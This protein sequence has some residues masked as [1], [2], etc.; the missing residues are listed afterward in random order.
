LGLILKP[1]GGFSGQKPIAKG[2]KKG[3]IMNK[4]LRKK[5]IVNPPLQFKLMFL[6]LL[7]II[8]PALLTF[9]TLFFFINRILIDAQINNEM[10]Y[11]ALLFMSHKVYVVLF[12]GF[13]L[14]TLLL[15]IWGTLFMHRIVGPLYRLGK[16]LD[17]F[18]EGKPVSKIHFRKNDSFSWL[19]EKINCLLE[20]IPKKT[21]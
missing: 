16:E 13:L 9:T 5:I 19:A 14:I 11:N 15:L 3:D 12:S 4:Q 2:I 20:R 8:I 10:V 21:Q 17:T 1:H 6:I 18:I 7:S